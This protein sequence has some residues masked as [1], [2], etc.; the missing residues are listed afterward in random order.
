MPNETPLGQYM[1]D[2][3]TLLERHPAPWKAAFHPRE[4]VVIDGRRDAVIVVET[5]EQAFGIAAAVNLAAG[6]RP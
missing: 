1:A 2:L 3:A 5:K 6:L 4:I